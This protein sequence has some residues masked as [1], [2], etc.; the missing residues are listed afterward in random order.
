MGLSAIPHATARDDEY[1]GY[2]IPKGTIVMGGLWSVYDFLQP[3]TK[4]SSRKGHLT[5]SRGLS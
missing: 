2:F 3:I 1:N 4:L 5:Q